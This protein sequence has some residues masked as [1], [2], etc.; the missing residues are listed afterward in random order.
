ME[1][2]VQIYRNK[3]QT[4]LKGSLDRLK[5][6]SK[7]GLSS[8]A[9]SAGAL[10]PL[11]LRKEIVNGIV[12][13]NPFLPEMNLIPIDDGAMRS[14]TFTYP[15]LNS[16]RRPGMYSAERGNG[17][18]SNAQTS[19]EQINHKVRKSRL[20]IWDF[21]KQVTAGQVDLVAMEL[22]NEI[23]AA[24]LDT[25]ISLIYDN[26]TLSNTN[27]T[28]FGAWEHSF[29]TSIQQ[30]RVQKF[31]AGLPVAMDTQMLDELIIAADI[32]GADPSRSVIY[33]SPAMAIRLSSIV[34][35]GSMTY[36]N[37]IPTVAIGEPIEVNAGIFIGAYKG[38]KLKTSTMCGGQTAGSNDVTYGISAIAG[39]TFAADTWRFKVSKVQ[40]NSSSVISNLAIGES[41]ASL[42]L[43]Q[44]LA[45]TE[46]VRITIPTGDETAVYYKI[47]AAI[48]A[49][50]TADQFRLIAVARGQTYDVDGNITGSIT[51]T[52]AI[53]N[54]SVT[55][56]ANG[57][58]ITIDVMQDTGTAALLKDQGVVGKMAEDL[59][60]TVGSGLNSEFIMLIDHSR[61]RG[62]GDFVYINEQ[63]DVENGFT[64]VNM[65][66]PLGDY[67]EF[68]LTSY[69]TPVFGFDG[70]SI[71][72]RGLRSA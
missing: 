53:S 49:A 44:V 14:K 27:T 56:D 71:M 47:Y 31:V 2:Q 35:P 11:P 57:N 70:S 32:G 51:N 63:A 6:V 39:G 37:Q 25:G 5:R 10:I 66:T 48:G 26:P 40:A 72:L 59:P 41:M 45:G 65:I 18:Y 4:A 12:Y 50:A 20:R 68:M 13:K 43:D 7:E 1:S 55:S 52:N 9:T 3:L 64:N 16:L 15:K 23:R 29:D 34:T 17:K 19:Q 33:M 61:I 8:D 62:M 69:G 21:V 38:Y 28:T 58:V 24:S 42:P 22:D 67:S 54:L 30:N 60:L 36:Y 46:G